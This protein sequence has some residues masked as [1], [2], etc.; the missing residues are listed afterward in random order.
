MVSFPPCKINLGLHIVS[1]RVD[2]FHELET[3]F[4]PVPWMDVLEIIPSNSFS[5]E[6]SG[7]A[8]PGREEDNICVKAYHLIKKDFS[9]AP[10][11]IYLHK[12]I[13]MGAGLGGGS[14]DGAHAL[15][16]LNQIFALN[17]TIQQ[18]RNYAVQ[19]GSDC[20]FFLESQPMLGTGRGEVLNKISLSLKGKFI[21][22]VKPEIH[23]STAD[24]YA[25]VNPKIPLRS[26]SDL[27]NHPI[28]EWKDIVI[29]DFENTV[30]AHYPDI[31]K[32][33]EKMYS[34]GAVYASMSG[35]GS[36]VFG[37]FDSLIETADSFKTMVH[38]S[39]KLN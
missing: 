15:I 37:I 19:L 2:G 24:A 32:L 7:R 18:L 26:F 27:I 10:V 9:I 21:F 5:F 39:G 1:K 20:P 28:Q 4:Y 11:K 12:I 3:I 6:S 30:F 25:S 16:L 22:I 31:R 38:W 33:K 35:S 36:S 17:L 23:V 29:N 14:S 8:I 13:P 34:A